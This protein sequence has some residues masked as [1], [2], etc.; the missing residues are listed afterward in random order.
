[1]KVTYTGRKIHLTGEIREKISEKLE[2]LDKFSAFVTGL[3]VVISAENEQVGV[4]LIAGSRVGKDVII[5]EVDPELFEAVDLAVDRLCKALRRQKEKK[6]ANSHGVRNT[7]ADASDTP[8]EEE[9][10]YEDIVN[11]LE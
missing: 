11:N 6:I 1:M 4:E 8:D 10:T 2:K 5:K 7:P 9:E 3:Q